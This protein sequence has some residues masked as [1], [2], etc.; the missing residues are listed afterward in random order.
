MFVLLT[1]HFPQ[2]L[3]LLWNYILLSD[4]ILDI[5]TILHN[6][7]QIINLSIITIKNMEQFSAR[8]FNKL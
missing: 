2:R 1:F 6:F 3:D 7:V 5:I 4:Q 8:T